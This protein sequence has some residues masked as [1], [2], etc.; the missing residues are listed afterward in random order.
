M[1]S[2]EGFIIYLLFVMRVQSP[3]GAELLGK[4]N[5]SGL[6][7]LGQRCF[8]DYVSLVGKGRQPHVL[9]FTQAYMSTW[10]DR[11]GHHW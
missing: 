10:Y 2:S 4:Y 1:W 7:K 5:V 8:R 6:S 11:Y 3:L 9:Q